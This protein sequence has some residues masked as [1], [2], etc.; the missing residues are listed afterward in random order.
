MKLY[1]WDDVLA[2]YS[3][4]IAFVMANSVE[5]AIELLKKSFNETYFDE[6]NKTQFDWVTEPKVYDVPTAGWCHGGG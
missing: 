1:I 2:D 3:G 6:N 5:E 4:G